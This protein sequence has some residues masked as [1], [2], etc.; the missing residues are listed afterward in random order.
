L[1]SIPFLWLTAQ[2]AWINTFHSGFSACSVLWI[3][4]C[5]NHACCVAEMLLRCSWSTD[6]QNDVCDNRMVDAVWDA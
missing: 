6:A 2:D 4:W 3:G 5:G 1:S